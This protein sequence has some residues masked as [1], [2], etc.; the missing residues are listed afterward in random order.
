M[1]DVKQLAQVNRPL[2]QP[3]QPDLLEKSWREP[4]SQRMRDIGCLMMVMMKVVGGGTL[5]GW[6]ARCMVLMNL[7][8]PM[9]IVNLILNITLPIRTM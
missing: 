1:E 7:A 6:M 9:F 2:Y 3:F 5:I 8:N 4:H